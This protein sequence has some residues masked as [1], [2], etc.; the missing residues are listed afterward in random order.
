MTGSTRGWIRRRTED[1]ARQSA[2][3]C[4]AIRKS[5]RPELNR[6]SRLGDRGQET[7]GEGKDD[8]RGSCR[9][10][11]VGG[12][13]PGV[14]PYSPGGRGAG[15]G[16]WRH[17]GCQWGINGQA[18]TA[19][20]LRPLVQHSSMGRRSFVTIAAGTCQ[21]LESSWFM[22]R[23]CCHDTKVSSSPKIHL[24]VSPP[25]LSMYLLLPQYPP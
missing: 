14:W 12:Q 17:E 11:R 25:I 3:S 19:H 7:I 22:S 9:S 18:P 20:T 24:V 1:G 2:G 10:G 5:P 23:R 4:G 8:S 21:I 15:P 16:G 13:S 6:R